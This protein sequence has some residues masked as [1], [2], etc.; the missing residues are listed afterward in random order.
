MI[1]LTDLFNSFLGVIGGR[2]HPSRVPEADSFF[3]RP[4]L[5]SLTEEIRHFYGFFFRGET[6]VWKWV[7]SGIGVFCLLVYPTFFFFSSTCL[8][9]QFLAQA[10]DSLALIPALL[11]EEQAMS[12]S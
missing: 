4:S 10:S 11:G 6:V 1:F 12:L 9:P 8:P 5:S 3:E 7:G 2:Q